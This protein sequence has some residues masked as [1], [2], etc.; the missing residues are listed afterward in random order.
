MHQNFTVGAYFSS[1]K[2]PGEARMASLQHDSEGN[3]VLF[4][5][6]VYRQRYNWVVQM[7]KQLRPKKA[8]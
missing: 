2:D 6:P 5:P 7:I 3:T 8:S 1:S 4:D